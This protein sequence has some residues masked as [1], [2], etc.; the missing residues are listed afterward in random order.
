MKSQ[1]GC[2]WISVALMIGLCLLAVLGYLAFRFYPP[3]MLAQRDAARPTVTIFAPQHGDQVVTGSTIVVQAEGTA[4]GSQVVL[5]QLW[6]DGA[7]VGER[8]GAAERLNT[9]W[10]WLPLTP[11]DH[12]LTVRAYNQRGDSGAAL[13][14][15][16]AIEAADA[17]RDG[18]PN[19]VDV[20]PDHSGLL[21]LDGCPPG[22]AGGDASGNPESQAVA[23]AW[24]GPGEEPQEQVQ[25]VSGGDPGTIQGGQQPRFEDSD[26]PPGQ[27]AIERNCAIC[28]WL[29][30]QGDGYSDIEMSGVG[31][32]VEVLSL[33]TASGLSDVACYVRLPS[34]Q[35]NQWGRAPDNQDEFFRPLGDGFWNIA[36]YLGGEHGVGVVVPEGEPL[37]VDIRCH[38]RLGDMLIPSLH[39]GE[40]T[41][42]H[43]PADWNGQTFT[44]RGQEGANWFDIQYRICSIPCEEGVIPPPYDLYLA[45]Q[46]VGG[47]TSYRLS[48]RWDG[49]PAMIDGFEIYRNGNYIDFSANKF[50]FL[51]PSTVEPQGCSQEYRFEVRA[52][53]GG[54]QSAPSNPAFSPA[55]SSCGGRNELEVADVTLPTP[56]RADLTVS[57]HYWYDGAH[58]DQVFV[59]VLPLQEG[60][61]P[62]WPNLFHASF[63]I[64]NAA[65]RPGGGDVPDVHVYYGG[66]Q[67]LTTDGLRLVMMDANNELFY[68]RDVPLTVLWYPSAPDL[69]WSGINIF[70]SPRQV[71]GQ[72]QR[73]LQFQVVNRGY[74]RLIWS[75]A[76]HV[77]LGNGQ[78]AMPSGPLG[79][80]VLPPGGRASFVWSVPEDIW[81]ALAPTYQ[82]TLDPD[83]VIAE[84]D[85]GNNTFTGSTQRLR[86]WFNQVS[87]SHP[88]EEEYVYV[89]L[90]GRFQVGY[91]YPGGT[92]QALAFRGG[93]HD[94]WID[95]WGEND[96]F[97]CHD[98]GVA[99]QPGWYYDVEQLFRIIN[100]FDVCY[101]HVLTH[102]GMERG[103]P[104]GSSSLWVYRTEWPCAPFACVSDTQHEWEEWC[105]HLIE[106]GYAP[107]RTYVDVLASP[108]QPLY[109]GVHLN[110][111]DV[112]TDGIFECGNHYDMICEASQDISPE[113]LQNLPLNLEIRGSYGNNH[114]CSVRVR[115][116]QAPNP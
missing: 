9:S 42:E 39:L 34:P 73:D 12:T 46:G 113:Q 54:Q 20:C 111:L 100:S 17:D 10:S 104:G 19:V 57:L 110:E 28:D 114:L 112:T 37:R 6:A 32:E 40:V 52:V 18:I 24:A 99:P 88:S 72:T 56:Q 55:L 83:N 77:R 48:W 94:E 81:L 86:V 98:E 61:P 75:P 108:D 35:W 36:D 3:L 21:Q 101:N 106:Q 23:D 103:A 13:V 59:F 109:V 27:I 30:E 84:L 64:T 97:Q 69:A 26:F 102:Y 62:G 44:A 87:T 71:D 11:G 89:G 5:I 63:S 90:N 7:L 74:T 53:K 79:N 22:M 49:D 4:R 47:L 92:L 85:E 95:N 60:S 82:V 68:I 76:L 1:K 14:R 116:E 50:A 45:G 31:L 80:I 115:I 2:L 78:L 43:G 65:I 8:E 33:R 38:G 58:G 67:P 16:T 96:L 51:S 93:A 15:V 91:R 25:G 41:R 105:H 29:E 70:S 107:D 66:S